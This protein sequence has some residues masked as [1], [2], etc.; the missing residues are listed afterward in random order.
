MLPELKKDFPPGTIV[1]LSESGYVNKDFFSEWLEYF[2]KHVK[3]RDGKTSLVL[4]G[5][6]SHR[7]NFDVPLYAAEHE[8]E[9]VSM[10]PHTRHYLQPFDKV[11]LKPLK[12][13]YKKAVLHL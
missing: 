2:C 4:D 3:E 9:I 6:G 11:H 10:P 13:Q 12:E 5:H 8:V 1:R 7:L